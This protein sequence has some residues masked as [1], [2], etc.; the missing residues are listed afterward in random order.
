MYNE[1]LVASECV[2]R[3]MSEISKLPNYV[4]LIVIDDGSNDSTIKIL[5][6]EKSKYKDKLIIFSSK[7]N[8]GYGDALSK[9]INIA[10]RGG[11]EYY[12]TMDSDL[13]NPPRYIRDFVKAMNK[14][15]DCIKAS[16]YVENGKVLNVP[17]FRRVIS[18]FG[19]NLARLF[20]GLGI[21]DYTNGFK[22]VRL[23]LLKDVKFKEKNFSIILEE[24]Y[25]LKKKKAK[26]V[27]IPNILSVRK[28]SKSHF[29]YTP[30]IF[31]DYFKYLFLALFA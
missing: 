28:N 23:S 22:M 10:I 13:T 11:F 15:V 9:G 6:N 19:N 20:F 18:I 16:R 4:K 7:K 14:N 5:E 30:I 27:E 31:Y 1:E 26:F 3:V 29:R 25:Y 21:K 12:I 17:L 2:K 24:M 8:G